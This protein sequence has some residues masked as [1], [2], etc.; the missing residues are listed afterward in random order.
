MRKSGFTLIELLVVMAMIAVL[1]GLLVPAVQRVRESASRLNCMNNLK[2]VSLALLNHHDAFKQ[3]PAGYSSAVDSLGNDT[4]P[5]WG[6]AARLLPHMEQEILFKA[7]D[8]TKP[9]ESPL[10]GS[11]RE[12]IIKPLL[13]PSDIGSAKPF[14]IGSRGA[15][16]AL[17]SV[18]CQVGP[19]NF[20]GNFGVGEPGVDGEGVLFRNSAVRIEDILDGSSTTFVVGER[21][22]RFAEAT[23]TG[24]VTG[25]AHGPTAVS[26]L[27]FV[28]SHPSNFV[29]SHT[30]ETYL[31]PGYPE[32][33]N[34]FS[35]IH[36][37]GGNF[38]FAD[39]HVSYL[40]RNTSYAT[41]KA[42]STRAGGESIRSGDY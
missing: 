28:E 30:G 33:T 21:S 1:L 3:L 13:C 17:G 27:P 32:E 20:V 24:A 7:V 6:W 8:F 37:G 4:G 40:S 9:V 29:L 12:A 22:F 2:Q 31:G 42:L 26:P 35:A 41:Y 10:N 38:G 25:S 5:G 16:G 14:P 39:G 11:A 15:S 23:W 19:S 18:I 34:H 36:L